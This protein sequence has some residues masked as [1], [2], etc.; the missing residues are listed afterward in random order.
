MTQ[1]PFFSIIIPTYNRANLI[2]K[3]IQSVIGQTYPEWELIIIDDGSTDSTN[4]VVAA[5]S[6][7]RIRYVYQTNQERCAARNLGIAQARG[8]YIC[9][10]DSDDYYLPER[11][12][13]LHNELSFRQFPIELFY[14]PML[15]EQNGQRVQ[16]PEE[17][18]RSSVYDKIA[19]SVIHSQQVCG[20]AEI[21]KE[22]QFDI[23]FYISEDMELWLRIARKYK[24]TFLK[25]QYSI[26]VVDHEDRSVNFKRNNSYADQ[27]QTLKHIFTPG[28]SGCV[29]SKRTQKL[30]LA[31]CYFG[32]AMFQIYRCNRFAAAMFVFKSIIADPN[33]FQIKFRINVL[34]KL[35]MF[36]TFESI[37]QLIHY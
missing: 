3:A 35:L 30:L 7:S 17:V 9:F 8:K 13:L 10:L 28:H 6:D 37:E 21:F 11:L 22:F 2:G 27:L 36:S 26:V 20:A 16:M 1:A 14:T 12:Q 19:L 25:D 18:P 29:I 5:I 32:I 33:S 23:R 4:E 15:H 24:I 34:R 31:N